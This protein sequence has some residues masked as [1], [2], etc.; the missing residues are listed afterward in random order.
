MNQFWTD[1]SLAISIIKYLT[2]AWTIVT[3]VIAFY[4]T[5]SGLIPVL[6]RLGNALS[7]RKIAIFASAEFDSLQDMLIDSKLFKKKNILKINHNDLDK[8]ANIKL[9][10]VHWKDFQGVI[11]EILSNKNDSTA[12]IVYAPQNEGRIDDAALSKIN[13]KRNSIIVN[14]RGRLLN[15]ILISMITAGYKGN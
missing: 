11:D 1:I 5:V 4:F 8:A 10:L 14:F 15:D 6:Y 3:V 2:L 13:L 7:S 9:F 12:L